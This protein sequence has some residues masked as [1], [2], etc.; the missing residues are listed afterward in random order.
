VNHSASWLP[1]LQGLPIGIW[2]VVLVLAVLGRQTTADPDLWGYMAFGKLFVR[3]GQFPYQD[4]FT[5]LPTLGLW[6]YHEW[7]TGVLFYLVYSKAG[8]YGLLILR[9]FVSLLTIAFV[10]KCSRRRGAPVVLGVL[11]IVVTAG[12]LKAGFGS[13]VRAQIFT[14][15]FFAVTLYCLEVARLN[16]RWWHLLILPFIFI[17]WCNLHGGYVAGLGLVGLYAAGEFLGRRSFVPYLGLLALCSVVT[18][19]NP[20]GIEYWRYIVHASTMPRPFITEWASLLTAYVH[21]IVS[22]AEVLYN[23]ILI[24]LATAWA[25]RAR[26]R[27]FTVILVLL[28]TLAVGLLHV[29]HIVF[30]Y[31]AM[32]CYIPSFTQGYWEGFMKMALISKLRLAPRMLRPAFAVGGLVA[33]GIMMSTAS[34]SLRIPPLP[35]QGERIYYPVGATEYIER[36]RLKGNLLTEFDWGE[37]LLWR[38]YPGIKVALDGRYETVYPDSICRQ[39]FDFLWGKTETLLRTYPPDLILLKPG[40]PATKPLLDSKNWRILYADEGSVLLERR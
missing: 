39:Y 22:P 24:V 31:L 30:F 13:V 2:F 32:A 33:L 5:Y 1:R 14:Y 3:S 17:V 38:L 7:L 37:F 19:V 26:L 23:A 28:T 25:L 4:V 18:L 6:V 12:F 20:Y 16:N 15:L 36:H 27:D 9:L 21:G 11:F 40:A 10:Y 35:A 8:G 34:F 29:R